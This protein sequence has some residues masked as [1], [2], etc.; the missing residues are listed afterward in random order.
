M[1]RLTPSGTLCSSNFAAM[2]EFIIELTAAVSNDP[3][4]L[5]AKPLS[6]TTQTGTT[7]S[8]TNPLSES[9]TD[10]LCAGSWYLVMNSDHYFLPP[11]QLGLR[12]LQLS[13]VVDG[14]L[15]GEHSPAQRILP[16]LG[17]PFV[18]KKTT[19]QS[20]LNLEN[21]RRQFTF[22]AEKTGHLCISCDPLQTLQV[23]LIE[24][25][26]ISVGFGL[27]TSVAKVFTRILSVNL[28]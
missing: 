2:R 12:L 25:Y 24:E 8:K 10:A 5:R 20:A 11:R 27:L 7:L 16:F 6:E 15:M 22:L 28:G 17:T 19:M 3:Q 1:F 18:N 21:R 26:F 23:S 14:D 13:V 4:V 9:V